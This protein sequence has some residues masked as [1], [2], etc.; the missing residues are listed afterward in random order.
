MK[1]NSK[2]VLDLGAGRG[3]M[4]SAFRDKEEYEVVTIDVNP[5]FSP[6][7]LIDLVSAVENPD[8][9]LDFWKLQPHVILASPPCNHFSYAARSN[10]WPREGIYKG[11]RTAGA[12][13][14]VIARMHPPYWILENPRGY[15]RYFIGTAKVRL[16]L[17]RFGYRT[18]K[19]TDFWTNLNIGLVP[20]AGRRNTRG[21]FDKIRDPSV[22]AEMPY[23]LSQLFCD[24]VSGEK[25]RLP[26]PPIKGSRPGKNPPNGGETGK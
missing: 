14:E 20:E 24:S 4:S 15:L 5:R 11:L 9:Y 17:N 12:F 2:L 26:T 1:E 22:R 8:A 3:G 21:S 18:V 25:G 7:L 13:M 19:P 10:G 16:N 23:G 6:S